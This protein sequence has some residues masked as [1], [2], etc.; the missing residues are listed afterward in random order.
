[1]PSE[2]KERDE[3]GGNPKCHKQNNNTADS[4]PVGYDSSKC[5]NNANGRNDIT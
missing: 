4:I 2:C 1:M 5:R 3:K